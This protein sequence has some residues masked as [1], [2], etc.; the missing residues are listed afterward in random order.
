MKTTLIWMTACLLLSLLHPILMILLM[1]RFV[2]VGSTLVDC[3]DEYAY[4][5]WVEVFILG[6]FVGYISFVFILLLPLIGIGTELIMII[7]GQ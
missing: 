4:F 2:C 7:K 6:L 1:M 3:K 5:Y